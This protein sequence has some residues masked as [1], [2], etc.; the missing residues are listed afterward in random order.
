MWQVSLVFTLKSGWKRSAFFRTST[1]QEKNLIYAIVN[2]RIVPFG[3]TQEV[4]YGMVSVGR[5]LVGV[6]SSTPALF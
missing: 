2:V 3:G 6:P 4:D 5:H 1:I